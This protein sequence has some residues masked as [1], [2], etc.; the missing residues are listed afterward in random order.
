M[1]KLLF[2]VPLL[3]ASIASFA[4]QP[5]LQ[6][7]PAEKSLISTFTTS[8]KVTSIDWLQ[9]CNDSGCMD[10]DDGDYCNQF[11][12]NYGPGNYGSYNDCD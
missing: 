9:A 1:K 2:V 11:V 5:Q 8:I 6:N 3:L 12:W 7:T 10:F 4:S